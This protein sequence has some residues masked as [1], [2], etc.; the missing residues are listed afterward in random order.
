MTATAHQLEHKL[1][2]VN[3]GG[4][5]QLNFHPGQ[6]QVWDSKKRFIFAMAGTRSGKT[7]QAPWWLYREI[8]RTYTS[9]GMND[10]LTVS[11]TVDLFNNAFL[12]AMIE[13]FCEILD[14][15][16]YWA[17]PRVLEL[18][19]LDPN[20]SRYGD[21]Y[22]GP[23]GRSSGLMWARIILR[24]S[25]SKGSLESMTAKAAVLDECGMDGFSLEDWEAVQRR[26][27]IG[28]ARILGTTTPYDL[29][30]L[31]STVYSA[32]L[33]GDPDIDVIHFPSYYN[34]AFDMAEYER[35]KRTMPAWR[36]SL[37]YDGKFQA[38]AGLI[39]RD[40]DFS[41][42]V[43]REEFPIPKEWEHVVGID[44]GGA[45]TATVWLALNPSDGRWYLY[46]TTHMGHM[47]TSEHVAIA[48]A[49]AEGI[50]K[51][52][53]VGGAKSEGQQRDDWW[54]EGFYVEE[55]PVSDLE[56]GIARVIS[57]IKKDRLRIFN[58]CQ[59]ILNEIKTY[60][61]KMDS[62]NE[63]TEQIINKAGYHEGDALRYACSWIE[64]DPPGAEAVTFA[65]VEAMLKKEGYYL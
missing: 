26:V 8:M 30:W 7:S 65:Q 25:Q 40:F 10:Y 48:K 53:V 59:G 63:P 28:S 2:Q 41:T 37:F 21:F 34:P 42:M 51:L 29:G 43:V 5:L 14:I 44:F 27:S 38:P 3:P 31:Y 18:K 12:P 45:N 58:S 46:H 54:H 56:A 39:Y 9:G 50:D 11:P 62:Q 1:Y 16:H 20:D 4:E 55:P 13:V 32:W 64:A 15:G 6:K 24:S 17:A 19:C 35:A 52:T 47:P 23:N 22:E 36:F 33:Q 61:R 60:R 57:L 49:Q